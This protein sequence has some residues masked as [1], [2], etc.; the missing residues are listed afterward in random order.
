MKQSKTETIIQAMRILADDIQSGDGVANAAIREAAD[1]LEYLR[2]I[3]EKLCVWTP[4]AADQGIQLGILIDRLRAHAA[5]HEYIA[6]ADDEQ[7]QWMQ[8]LHEAADRLEYQR[9]EKRC[10]G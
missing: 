1:R 9:T 3:V 6:A 8:D 7:N 2:A 4:D 5:A 10:A